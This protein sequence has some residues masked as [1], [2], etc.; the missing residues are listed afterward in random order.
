[1]VLGKHTLKAGVNYTYQRS[2]NVFLPNLNGAFRLGL[3]RGKVVGSPGEKGKV[4][5]YPLSLSFELLS[6]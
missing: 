4:H 5:S 2:P 3:S 1:M 6:G